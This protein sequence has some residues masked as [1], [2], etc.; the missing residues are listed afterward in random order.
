MSYATGNSEGSS[1]PDP[2]SGEILLGLFGLGQPLEIPTQGAFLYKVYAHLDHTAVI[3]LYWNELK[4]LP[5]LYP[6][7][8][9]QFHQVQQRQLVWMSILGEKST[10]MRLLNFLILLLGESGEST[11][12][13]CYLPYFLSHAQIGSAIRST[14]VTITR[15]MVKLRAQNV[16]LSHAQ[17]LIA[18]N[19]GK[20]YQ[21]YGL[22]L[23]K[24][25]DKR[26]LGIRSMPSL[27]DTTRAN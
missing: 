14:R 9:E 27:T 13:A 24:P 15:L 6:L 26:G 4:Q 20:L 16:I 8:L 19:P 7:I 1:E 10:L 11:D 18:I 17:N 12:T 25:S 23:E 21:T 5:Y 22:R 2:A 3:W